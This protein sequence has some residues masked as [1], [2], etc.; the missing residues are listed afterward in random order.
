VDLLL[1]ILWPGVQLPSVRFWD[2]EYLAATMADAGVSVA[3]TPNGFDVR[4]SC[5]NH[6]SCH[7]SRA[8][9]VTRAPDGKLYFV[10]P[11]VQQMKMS[12]FLSKLS[13]GMYGGRAFCADAGFRLD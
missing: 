13:S 10:E 5:R 12:E 6:S 9:A 4:V 11:H 7:F 1:S 2:D 3:V 8:D